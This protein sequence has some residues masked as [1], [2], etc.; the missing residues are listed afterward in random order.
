MKKLYSSEKNGL[1]QIQM[2][3]CQP[4]KRLRDKKKI[5]RKC[6]K[7]LVQCMFSIA[8][9]KKVVEMVSLSSQDKVK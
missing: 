8:I 4:I 3:S 5:Q 9:S 1:Q 6:W 7:V 2:E